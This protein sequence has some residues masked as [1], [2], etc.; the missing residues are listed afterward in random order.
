MKSQDLPAFGMCLTQ[1]KLSS[2]ETVLLL[3]SNTIRLGSV[4]AS[5]FLNACI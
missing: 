5:Q 4:H 1:M 2:F 3:L